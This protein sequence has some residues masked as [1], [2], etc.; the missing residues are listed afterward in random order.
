M[1]DYDLEIKDKNF[2]FTKDRESRM[3]LLKNGLLE[4]HNNDGLYCFVN[5]PKKLMKFD[6]KKL[7]ICFTNTLMF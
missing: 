1:T 3:V 4:L 6:Y 5:E 2:I 7:S